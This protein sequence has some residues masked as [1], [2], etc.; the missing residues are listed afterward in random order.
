[1]FYITPLPDLRKD[2]VFTPIVALLIIPPLPAQPDQIDDLAIR[3][4]LVDAVAF[5]AS[6]NPPVKLYIIYTEDLSKIDTTLRGNGMFK[7]LKETSVFLGQKKLGAISWTPVPGK[8]KPMLAISYA[9]F[10]HTSAG[11][12]SRFY[13]M[14]RSGHS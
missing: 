12:T 4:L 6:V 2:I 8:K 7:Q 10:V 11:S 1:M 14:N 9:T 3:A 5:Y 13:L